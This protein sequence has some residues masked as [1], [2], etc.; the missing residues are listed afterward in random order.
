MKRLSSLIAAVLLVLATITLAFPSDAVYYAP[1]GKQAMAYS[2]VVSYN[3]RLIIIARLPT[4]PENSIDQSVIAELFQGDNY[5]SIPDYF[6]EVSHNQEE[7][8]FPEIWE[9]TLDS[10]YVELNLQEY[11]DDLFWDIYKVSQDI[12]NKAVAVYGKENFSK[13]SSVI[14]ILDTFLGSPYGGNI[15]FEVGENSHCFFGVWLSQGISYA[16]MKCR[17]TMDVSVHEM[18]HASK[19]PGNGLPSGFVEGLSH[20]LCDGN[21]YISRWDPVGDCAAFRFKRDQ[22]FGYIPIHISAFNKWLL[23]WL[24]NSQIVYAGAGKSI[25]ELEILALPESGKKM[26]VIPVSSNSCI[27]LEV[28]ESHGNYDVFP[29]D[30]GGVVPYLATYS[31]GFIPSLDTHPEFCF[32]ALKLGQNLNWYGVEIKVE[33]KTPTGYKISITNSNQPNFTPPPLLSFTDAESHSATIWWGKNP[34]WWA[35]G[36]KFWFAPRDLSYIASFQAGDINI[37]SDVVLWPG[38]DFYIAIQPNG[39]PDFQNLTNIVEFTV[40]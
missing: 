20:V 25:I 35:L 34:W 24:A 1:E 3:D 14:F 23:G 9:V 21:P 16:G 12:I 10:D 7:I 6:R 11:R 38:A 17:V 13:Y 33:A 2:Q 36:Q 30:V 28:R 8:R 39:L 40:P 32:K 31:D 18:L 19:T 26:A 37:L 29:P 5:P 4:V 15:C 27:V 22:G